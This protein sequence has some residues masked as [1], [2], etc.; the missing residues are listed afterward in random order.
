VIALRFNNL[1]RATSEAAERG[2]SRKMSQWSNK[3]WHHSVR[4]RLG[5]HLVYYR[6]KVQPFVQERI[7]ENLRKLLCDERMPSLRAFLIFGPY[8]LLFRGWIHPT[9]ISSF[10]YKLAEALQIDTTPEHFAVRNVMTKSYTN[11]DIQPKF[12]EGLWSQILDAQTIRSVQNGENPQ[13]LEQLIKGGFAA[14]KQEHRPQTLRFFT[15][16]TIFQQPDPILDNLAKE[17]EAELL[18][19]RT[20]QRPAVYTGDGF[21]NILIKGEVLTSD[22]FAIGNLTEWLISKVGPYKGITATYLGCTSNPLIGGEEKIDD[23]TFIEQR[24]RDL[25]V[26]HIIPEVYSDLSPRADEIIHFLL[27]HVRGTA[28]DAPDRSLIGSYLSGYLHD[29]PDTSAVALLLYFTR[30]E[31]YL[32]KT[33]NKFLAL[34]NLEQAKIYESAGISKDSTRHLALGDYLSAFS[35]AIE[36][37]A[38]PQ[39]ETLKGEWQDLVSV[40]NQPAHGVFGFTKWRDH[41][42]T[43]VHHLPRIRALLQLIANTT[44][45][46]PEFPHQ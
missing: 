12:S 39:A 45:I 38:W 9:I 7:S 16:V 31:A 8:D 26:E 33:L 14:V 41:V 3:V 36:K 42:Q 28:L 19:R 18:G 46:E 24:G 15:T 37:L 4:Q 29:Q 23:R 34:T 1:P 6:A 21:C 2:T 10:R 35:K 44:G 13:L 25:F 5:E 27:D 43:L 17:I 11:H 20:I 40:R 22:Y 30:L 32:R